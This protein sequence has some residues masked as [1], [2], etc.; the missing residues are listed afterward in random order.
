MPILCYTL[1]GDF[2]YK[3]KQDEFDIAY[4]ILEEAFPSAEL[5]QYNLMKHFFDKEEV[6]FFGIKQNNELAVVLLSWEFDDFA[7]LENFAVHKKYR[8]NGLGSVCLKKVK[9]YYK[10]PIVLEVEKPYDD[11]SKRR[12]GFYERN[13]FILSTYGYN[14]PP[15]NKTINDIPL[16][17][18]RY[19]NALDETTFVKI[20]KQIFNRVYQKEVE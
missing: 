12:I 18:M 3:I 17:M 10:V 5:R 13:G 4:A 19:P 20:K 14:Q 1:I 7:F 11:I 16:V 9:E 15:L 2:M 8:N 6:I